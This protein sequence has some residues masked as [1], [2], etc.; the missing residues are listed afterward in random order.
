MAVAIRGVLLMLDLVLEYLHLP[1]FD[2]VHT[3]PG[4]LVNTVQDLIIPVLHRGLQVLKRC[5]QSGQL[6]Y[7]WLGKACLVK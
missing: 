6:S 2:E 3:Q 4:L 7:L 5:S 1:V